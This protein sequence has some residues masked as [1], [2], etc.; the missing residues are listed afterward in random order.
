M[1][2]VVRTGGKQYRVV[3]GDLVR[4]D[5]MIAEQ[6]STVILDDVL[7]VGS[8]TDVKHGKGTTVTAEV[9]AQFKDDKITVFK[10]KRRHNYRRKNGH[11]QQLTLLRITAIGDVKAEIAPKKSAAA[12]IEVVAPAAA[13]GGLDVNNLSLISGVGPT[14]EKKLR[15]AGINTWHD[16]AAW[17]DD[18]MVRWNDELK[19]GHRPG[20]EQ[21]V[22]QAK[23]LLDGKPPRAKVDQAE[24]KS[25][26]DS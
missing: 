18:D 11:R 13:T 14:I 5:K 20:R 21:W 22:E 9:V 10:K 16:I 7:L 19:L 3:G 15:A 6:G 1:Y 25:G 8:G 4:V 26:K 12:K 24:A 2:A 17:S 23:E